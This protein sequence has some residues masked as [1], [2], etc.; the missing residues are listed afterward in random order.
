MLDFLLQSQPRFSILG[1]ILVS[2][3]II[4]SQLNKTHKLPKFKTKKGSASSCENLTQGDIC[5]GNHKILTKSYH[6]SKEKEQ[7]HTHTH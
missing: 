6:A 1:N 3:Y 2:Q 7:Q 5:L 4:S